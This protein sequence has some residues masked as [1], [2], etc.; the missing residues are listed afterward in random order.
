MPISDK[1]TQQ[2]LLEVI[3]DAHRKGTASEIT[4]AAEMVREIKRQIMLAVSGA[5]KEEVANADDECIA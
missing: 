4:G 1:L 3:V 2:Q 5:R